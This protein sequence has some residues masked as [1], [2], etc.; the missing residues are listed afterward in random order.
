MLASTPFLPRTWELDLLAKIAENY[1]ESRRFNT[2][3]SFIKTFLIFEFLYPPAKIQA[4]NRLCHVNTT[5]T[6]LVAL[7][8]RRLSSAS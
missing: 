1:H 3:P 5:R 2:W 6:L 8:L 7:T 4:N